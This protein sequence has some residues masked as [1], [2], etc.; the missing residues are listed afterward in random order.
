MNGRAA[1]HNK[2][3]NSIIKVSKVLAIE[4]Y[5]GLC[6]RLRAYASAAA[7]AKLTGRELILIWQK[8][9]H[10]NFSMEDLFTEWGATYTADGDVLEILEASTLGVVIYDYIDPM[11]KYGT[12][13]AREEAHIYVR[14]SVAL[15]AEPPDDLINDILRNLKYT[16]AV[17]RM[18]QNAASRLGDGPY[19]GAHIRM[20]VDQSKDIPGITSVSREVPIGIGRANLAREFRKSCHYSHFIEKI[21]SRLPYV[22]AST[23]IFVASDSPDAITA[24][25]SEFGARVVAT[26][27]VTSA[28]CDGP[29]RRGAFC[30]QVALSEFVLLSRAEFL[31]TSE[32]S[33]ASEIAVRL[34]NSEYASGC[35]ETKDL[36]G[37]NYFWD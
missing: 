17:H 23:K 24:L 35:R 22:I 18:L 2:H 16:G 19:I 29:R 31:Y 25:Q 10:T 33:S 9:I 11:E 28:F 15:K 20:L 30:S 27:S 6:N 13:Y 4:V 5:Y 1:V 12:I 7:L 36:H 21:R 26:P 37:G 3:V 14:S 34:S 32:W 8:D